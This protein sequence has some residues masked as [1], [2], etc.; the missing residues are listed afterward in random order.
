M[1]RQRAGLVEWRRPEAPFPATVTATCLFLSLG[2]LGCASSASPAPLPEVVTWE[3]RETGCVANM[4]PAELPSRFR[5][6]NKMIQTLKNY[7]WSTVKRE[8]EQIGRSAEGRLFA[9]LPKATGVLT[10]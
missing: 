10:V 1:G 8:E 3:S 4:S 5:N 7:L 2:C 6:S 9:Q